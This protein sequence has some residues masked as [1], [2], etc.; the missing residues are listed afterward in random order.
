[1]APVINEIGIT[2]AL[3]SLLH[4]AYCICKMHV[5]KFF[6]K[7]TYSAVSEIINV[8]FIIYRL[9]EGLA[10]RESLNVV[11]KILNALNAIKMKCFKEKSH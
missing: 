1:M 2:D 3:L 11:S 10:L 6:T 8:Y 9:S 7:S 5:L 4:F